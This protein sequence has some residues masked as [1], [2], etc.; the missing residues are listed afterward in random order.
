MN[1]R[2]YQRHIVESC[3]RDKEERA[4]IQ[5]KIDVEIIYLQLQDKC[6]LVQDKCDLLQTK[7]DEALKRVAEL[8]EWKSRHFFMF[9]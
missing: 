6:D 1:N 7:L 2:D 8:E 3:K 4:E 9:K 5:N